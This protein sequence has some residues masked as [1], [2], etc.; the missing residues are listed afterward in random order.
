MLFRRRPV[1]C[2]SQP[3]WKKEK[4]NHHILGTTIK[5]AC[6]YSHPVVPYKKWLQKCSVTSCPA[7]HSDCLTYWW[8]LTVFF[9]LCKS[10]SGLW[11]KAIKCHV[12]WYIRQDLSSV[13]SNRNLWLISS[14]K[15]S[16]FRPLDS[17][18]FPW[19]SWEPSSAEPRQ[20]GA[21]PLHH[22]FGCSFLPLISSTPVRK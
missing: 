5:M 1:F 14:G 10:Y 3:G 12:A 22:L 9:L 11:P 6:W 13:V 17:S 2:I 4:K 19:E 8:D 21:T 7:S 15:K 16:F 18:Q 20:P